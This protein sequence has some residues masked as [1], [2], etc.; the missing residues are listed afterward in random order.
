MLEALERGEAELG[1]GYDS[2][3]RSDLRYEP[4][5][6]EQQQLYC[7]RSHPLFG[8]RIAKP[9]DLASEGFVLTGEDEVETVTRFR[10]RYGLGTVVTGLAEDLHEATRLITLGVGIGFLPTLA[11]E[12]LVR[13]ERL[14]PLLLESAEPSY[15]IYLFARSS[16]SRDTATQLFLDEIIRRMRAAPRK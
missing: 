4:L 15:D 12:E 3:V 6:I 13:K 8:R 14:W 2:A 10:R 9:S 5:F 7:A 1:V 11:A 16:S